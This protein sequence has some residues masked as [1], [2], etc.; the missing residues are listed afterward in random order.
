MTQDEAMK[1]RLKLIMRWVLC[2]YREGD[3]GRKQ[4]EWRR[5]Q[6]LSGWGILG[7]EMMGGLNWKE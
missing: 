5:G 3:G 4:M 2:W 7:K 1:V 6:L